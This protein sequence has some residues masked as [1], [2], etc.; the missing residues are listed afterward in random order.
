MSAA[1]VRSR[2]Y[3]NRAGE[4]ITFSEYARL[5]EDR[6]YALVD[7]TRV[8]D[9]DVSTVWL[10]IDHRWGNGP[11]AI[12]ETMVFKLD[13]RGL[14]EHSTGEQWRYSTE[15]EARLGHAAVVLSLTEKN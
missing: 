14:R 9:R 3:F 8:G 12:F 1:D 10:G 5:I 2:V 13:A 7:C 11:I 4:P 15:A 6:S